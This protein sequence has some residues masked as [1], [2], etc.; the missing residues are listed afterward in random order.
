M[1][2]RELL[3]RSQNLTLADVRGG[4]RLGTLAPAST[5]D[6]PFAANLGRNLSKE[7]SSTV[8]S[9]FTLRALHP[10]VHPDKSEC[11][12]LAKHECDR[13]LDTKDKTDEMDGLMFRERE[14]GTVE[15]EIELGRGLSRRENDS[16]QS[17]CW[18]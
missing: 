10:M 11:A 6:L 13:T 17:N 2:D 15:I 4:H 5:S 14:R 1:T 8:P 12:S 18:W 3:R 16:L 7:T 9:G